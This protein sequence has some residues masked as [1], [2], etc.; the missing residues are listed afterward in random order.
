M[1]GI[2][3]TQL[4][5]RGLHGWY[6]H[7]YRNPRLPATPSRKRRHSSA[8]LPHPVEE[9]PIVVY[10]S[11]GRIRGTIT[12]PNY[13]QHGG[14]P[15]PL[16]SPAQTFA[17]RHA[18]AHHL[19]LTSGTSLADK[20]GRLLNEERVLRERWRELAR[21]GGTVRSERFWVEVKAKRKARDT[22][23]AGHR[24]GLLKGLQNALLD[25]TLV[26]P[27]RQVVAFDD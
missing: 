2:L 13:T 27:R 4:G 6:G 19:V 25:S 16:P 10:D 8:L 17:L 21:E 22:F 26:A 3:E 9:E 11:F 5:L 14:P 12:L 18:A 15:L 24:K 1:K 23:Q 20:E 7:T